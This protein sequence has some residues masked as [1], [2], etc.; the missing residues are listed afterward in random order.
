MSFLDDIT[1]IARTK[2]IPAV[3]GASIIIGGLQDAN[4]LQSGSR[5]GGSSFR[6]SSSPRSSTSR[7]YS[8]SNSY[9]S[10]TTIITPSPFYSPFGY[11]PFGYSPF[12]GFIPINFNVIIVAGLAYVLYNALNNRVGGGDFSMDEN[13]GALGSGT[14]LVKISVA[15]ESDWS[16]ENNIMNKLARTASKYSAMAD[17][18][19]LANLLSESALSLLR[20]QKDWSA[21]SYQSEYFNEANAGKVEAAFQTQAIRE[22]SKFEDEK[23]PYVATLQADPV[24]GRKPTQAVVSI[25]VAL[26]GKSSAVNKQ[27]RSIVDLKQCLE[28]L[29]G[30]AQTDEGDNIMA[31]EVLWTPS[32]SNTVLTER[33]LIMD[34]PELLRL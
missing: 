23:A 25:V 10:S 9:S 6:R 34:Y 21:S 11:S 33:D 1:K 26:R 3:I 14:S 28:G 27:V 22:R 29:A 20:Q 32:D 17:R 7:S 30:D 18:K 4:A 31:V 12:G 5:S 13:T 2:F 15:V 16:D 8:S 24:T 19:D